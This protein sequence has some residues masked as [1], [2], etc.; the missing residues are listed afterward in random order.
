MALPVPK[1]RHH[2]VHQCQPLSALL[3]SI[4]LSFIAEF[5]LSRLD[6]ADADDGTN[7]KP[8]LALVSFSF[9]RIK[10]IQSSR[11]PYEIG[12]ILFL[13]YESRTVSPLY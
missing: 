8:Q 2:L 10:L 12:L 7:N 6:D 5:C 13:F 4:L 3:C 9:T 11:P 1:F